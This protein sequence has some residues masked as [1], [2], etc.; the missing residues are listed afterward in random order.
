MRYRQSLTMAVGTDGTVLHGKRV[1]V[2]LKPRQTVGSEEAAA[3]GAAAAVEGVAVEILSSDWDMKPALMEPND[4]HTMHQTVAFH[5][6]SV[7]VL[8]FVNR[9][10]QR[11]CRCLVQSR[12]AG[13]ESVC[14]SKEPCR[15][16]GTKTNSACVRA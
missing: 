11:T 2:L 15:Q 3:V 7:D 1:E 9:A 4:S 16:Q 5:M 13:L 12:Y 14:N 10:R 6:E 8:G